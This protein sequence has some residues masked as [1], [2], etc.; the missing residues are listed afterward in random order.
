MGLKKKKTKT[1]IPTLCLQLNKLQLLPRVEILTS[2]LLLKSPM[3]ARLPDY[4]PQSVLKDELCLVDITEAVAAAA[5]AAKL[6]ACSECDGERK[7][8][9]FAL[10]AEGQAGIFAVGGAGLPHDVLAKLTL[11]VEP[12]QVMVFEQPAYLAQLFGM[13][14]PRKPQ[15]DEKG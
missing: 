2:S 8:L 4:Q 13:A 6:L 9:H 14:K 3:S 15:R 7:E 10:S 1:N 11:L 12:Q 5:A